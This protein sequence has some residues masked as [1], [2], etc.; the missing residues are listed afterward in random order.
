MLV[1]SGENVIQG[2]LGNDGA[3]YIG[4]NLREICDVR[5]LLEG[6]AR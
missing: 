2:K 4:G 5:V 3:K 6:R 1:T